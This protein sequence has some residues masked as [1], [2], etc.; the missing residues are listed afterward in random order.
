[1][2]RQ[3][4]NVRKKTYFGTEIAVFGPNIQFILGGIES[5]GT[6]ISENHLAP[7]SHCF[8]GRAWHQMDQQGQSL[9]QNDQKCIFWAKFDRFWTKNPALSSVFSGYWK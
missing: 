7:R 2:S 1:M 5:S 8:F 3:G 6:H 9:A 4:L